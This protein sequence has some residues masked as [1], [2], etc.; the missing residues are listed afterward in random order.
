M[1]L[2]WLYFFYPS[3]VA[4]RLHIWPRCVKFCAYTVYILASTFSAFG[5]EGW[6]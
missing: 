5:S 1:Y 3:M 6:A 2:V 4:Y